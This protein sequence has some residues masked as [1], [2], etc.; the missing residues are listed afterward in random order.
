L[1][2]SGAV[3]TSHGP[4]IAINARPVRSDQMHA[5][6]DSTP[7]I[8]G[9]TSHRNLVASEVDGLREKVRALI[10]QLRLQFPELPLV[11]LSALA[12]G[13]DRLV[14]EE[15][16]DAGAA[17]IAVLPMPD[18][19]YLEDFESRE[20]REQYERLKQRA[21]FVRMPRSM[22][23]PAHGVSPRGEPRDAQYAAA[24]MFIASH[25][26]VLLA[27]WDG[28]ESEL[29]GG[30]AQI[31]RYHMDGILPGAIERRRVTRPL[32]DLGDE[33]LLCH[34]ACSRDTGADGILPPVEPLAPL[35]M[36]W[37]TQL[38]E[39]PVVNGIPGEFTRMFERMVGFNRDMQRYRQP[40]AERHRA[41]MAEAD[42]QGGAG[43][44]IEPLFSAA[45][46][47][48]VHF[49][50]RVLLTLRGIHVLGALMGIAFV[51]YSD[52]PGSL[53]EQPVMIDLF[54]VLFLGGVVL[55]RMAHH[56]DWHR[57]YIDYRALAE[58]LR[59]QRYWRLAGI[60]ADE[61]VAFAHDNFMQKQDIELG[62]IRN[63][64]R[65]AGLDP[66]PGTD[67]DMA[68][69]DLER[70]IGE[71]IGTSSGG[72]QLAYYAS[73]CTERSHTVTVARRIGNLCLWTGIALCIVLA[74]FH[75]ML[76]TDISTYLVAVIGV[77]A[78]VAA[79]RESYAYRKADRELI[80]QYR[81]MQHLFTGARKSLDAAGDVRSK[82]EILR[83]LGDASLAEHA[84]WA[85][86]HR[87]RPL[88]HG[89]L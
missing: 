44:Y 58:G 81:F 46:W 15:G 16:L 13:G 76:D 78:F 14:A 89:R 77:L 59:V 39:H 7:L 17:L 34:L 48:A 62:W 21:S 56:R 50:K 9:V 31:V 71:W 72:G 38:G 52:L 51:A 82:R 37:I 22:H 24:G 12:E 28:R 2:D 26:H 68:R 69:V 83:E 25:C 1:P 3:P 20:S 35:E 4:V 49:Q 45:D 70:T 61:S 10:A 64:M 63:V 55:A 19:A 41:R 36:R 43:R 57:K 73:K 67:P 23:S 8:L 66:G 5:S 60:P 74:V 40:I 79:A 53:G 54:I 80:K 30:T 88:E 29:A 87:E 18:S 65:A 27:I 11:V 85:L 32:L 84:E 86:M 47:L 42:A 33:S 75:R 6:I